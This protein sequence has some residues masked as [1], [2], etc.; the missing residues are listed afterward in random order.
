VEP[1]VQADMQSAAAHE[2]KYDLE[3]K[4]MLS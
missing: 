4:C 2:I 1:V 3:I